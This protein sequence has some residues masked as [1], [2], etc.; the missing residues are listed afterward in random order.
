MAQEISYAE[1]EC[2]DQ[3][4]D[5]QEKSGK[6]CP[7][8]LDGHEKYAQ[9]KSEKNCPPRLDDQEKD[10]QEKPG[11]NCP[12]QLD[13]QEKDDQEMSGDSSPRQLDD[14]T[15]SE[16][17]IGL[18]GEDPEIW[19]LLLV[20][21]ANLPRDP[22]DRK[23]GSRVLE[24]CKKLRFE[25]VVYEVCRV[26]R[27]AIKKPHCVPQ[28]YDAKDLRKILQTLDRLQCE[29]QELSIHNSY[30]QML[31]FN[32]VNAMIDHK[33][34]EDYQKVISH[35]TECYVRSSAGQ[36]ED[37][38]RT[39]DKYYDDYNRGRRWLET[40]KFFDGTG[41][42]LIAVATGMQ[43]RMPRYRVSL[44]LI[45]PGVG[46]STVSK[47][48]TDLERVCFEKVANYLPS[49]KEVVNVL[50]ADALEQYCR[51]CFL[52]G[53]IEELE[54]LNDPASDEDDEEADGENDDSDGDGED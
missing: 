48:W 43:V 12:R 23:D 25:N 30:V 49:L 5:A 27:T 2:C 52:P 38:Q 50:G 16:I 18:V 8:R 13:D 54:K 53:K 41:I 33:Q 29:R 35:L 24:A 47:S 39:K 28:G 44:T 20:D 3:E 46:A 21:F 31:L 42:V 32:A 14:Y 6:D 7:P 10:N 11:E 1:V 4:K 26:L 19:K 34:F 36:G 45:S 9:E 40:A 17:E 51:G 37:L 15:L 22:R